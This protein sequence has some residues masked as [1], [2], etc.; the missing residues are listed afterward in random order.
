MTAERS[1]A[2]DPARTLALLW[3]EASTAS[4]RGPSRALD[5]AAVVRTATDLADQEGLAAVTMRA[6]ARALGVVPMTLYTYVPGKEELLDLML[7]AAYARMSRTDTAGAP[8]RERL[9]AVADENRALFAAHPWAAEVST[10]R[11]PLGPGLMAKY[12]HELSA[13]DAL[14]LSDTEM[15]DCLT[16]LLS[17]VQANARAA[18][19]ATGA[20]AGPDGDDTRWWARVGPLLARVLDEQR[21]P[22]ASRVGTAAGQARG[23]AHDPD[24]AYHFGLARLLDGLAPLI[25]RC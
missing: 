21:Y 20:A 25:E 19:E 8:W 10:L 22:L 24:H 15:D 16:Y 1:G 23:S 17:F 7:D 6:V 14:G 5:L 11:P 18:H 12:E 9:T 4:R 2:G 13:F 3:G